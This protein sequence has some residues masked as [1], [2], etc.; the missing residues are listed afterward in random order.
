MQLREVVFNEYVQFRCLLF[1]IEPENISQDDSRQRNQMEENSGEV[2]SVVVIRRELGENL[3]TDPSR[4]SLK[5]NA[6]QLRMKDVLSLEQNQ[7]LESRLIP[8][9]QA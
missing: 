1:L 3:L 4:L 5:I 2:Y 9:S 6:L 8:K 7:E